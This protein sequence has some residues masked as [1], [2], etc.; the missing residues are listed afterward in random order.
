VEMAMT[1]RL[2]ALTLAVWASFPRSLQWGLLITI[3]A[4]L[5]LL[6]EMAGLPAALL[7]GP[8]IA[9]AAVGC[10]G[11]S[12]QI[13]RLIYFGS[14]AVIGCLIARSVTSTI[15]LTFIEEWP[16]FLG[17]TLVVVGASSLLG[18]LINRWSMLP[19][20]TA[21]WG[22][23]PGA[24]TAMMLMAPSFGA[25]AR[26]VAFMQYLRVVLVAGTASVVAKLWAGTTSHPGRIEWFPAIQWVPFAETLGLAILGAMAGR[27]LRIPA[28]PLL[29][30]WAVGSILHAA[31]F[32]EIVL[33]P[34]LLAI[35]Y[36]L[37]G[38]R[39][40]LSFQRN[41]IAQATRALPLIV[42][43][44]L[45]LIASC[46]CLGFIL[47]KTMHIDS[48][49]AYLATSPG[50]M[51]S[52]AIIGATSNVDLPFVMAFQTVRFVVVVLVGPVIARI[53][54]RF[55]QKGA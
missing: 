1:S 28:G 45:V 40:G 44:F 31:G 55:S 41:I 34:W 38:W 39:I 4:I 8:M 17:V 53:L 13:S 35:C 15:V 3:S 6:L 14:Q 22:C 11:G 42:A 12:I 48:L 52:I 46:G 32:F 19:G 29:V 16:L 23:S 51:D 50:G 30:P 36:A 43:S 18:W 27:L 21:I 37:V 24:A 10:A 25:D 33:P 54:S 47:T 20:T 49:T 26:L 2:H 9:G 7:L 5:A